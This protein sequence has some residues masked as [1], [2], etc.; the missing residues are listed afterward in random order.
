MNSNFIFV[1]AED[2]CQLQLKAGKYNWFYAC[3][4]YNS[5]QHCTNRL[6]LVD[7]ER[8][9]HLCKNPGT[10]YRFKNYD[11]FRVEKDK[12]DYIYIRRLKNDHIN[13]FTVRQND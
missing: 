11:V 9:A 7:A 4:K 1:C 8:I 3:P 12:I 13:F 5:K 2:G 6:S 10:L